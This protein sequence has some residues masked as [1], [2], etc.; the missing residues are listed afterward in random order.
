M[1][2]IEMMR[3]ACTSPSLVDSLPVAFPGMALARKATYLDGHPSKQTRAPRV[4]RRAGEHLRGAGL[5]QR[6]A[7]VASHDDRNL[8]WFGMARK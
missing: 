3:G 6:K 8:E 2:L 1:C 5:A 7:N 4:G